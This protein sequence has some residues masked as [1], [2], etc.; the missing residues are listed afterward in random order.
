[1]TD[2]WRAASSGIEFN[3]R[4]Q[5]AGGEA[6]KTSTVGTRREPAGAGESHVETIRG[7]AA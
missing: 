7:L 2:A 6:S 5:H 1:M 4:M 3:R